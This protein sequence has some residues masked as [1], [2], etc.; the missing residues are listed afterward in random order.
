MDYSTAI[1]DISKMSPSEMASY[2]GDVSFSKSD[3]PENE[4][5]YYNPKKKD[6]DFLE[7]A[8][9]VVNGPDNPAAEPGESGGVP[10][11][12][13]DWTAQNFKNQLG[14]SSRENV[15]DNFNA[16]AGA[17]DSDKTKANPLLGEGYLSNDDFKRLKNDDKF[18]DLYMKESSNWDGS[19]ADRIKS[20]DFDWD[21]MS[22][23]HMDA[24][25]D[26]FGS[27][28]NT[29]EKETPEYKKSDVL[30][31]AQARNT[32]Y[33][34][35]VQGKQGDVIFGRN[36]DYAKDFADSY[37]SSLRSDPDYQ[38]RFERNAN[39]LDFTA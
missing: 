8:T 22:I 39:E 9:N 37:K 20:G 26:R 29:S 31:Q 12:V 17:T 16:S 2:F 33:N 3:M 23:N 7:T 28:M 10:S 34:E 6:S 18:R 32:A 30:A 11:S 5:D 14:L 24:F 4:D 13:S 15:G 25:L 27:K 36:P 1:K 38:W 35:V 19:K 21:E